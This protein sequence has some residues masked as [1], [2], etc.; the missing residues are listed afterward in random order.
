MI[1]GQVLDRFVTQSPITVMFR[2]TMENAFSADAIDEVFQ[3]TAQQQR[4][5]ELLF[6][7]VVDLWTKRLRR[8]REERFGPVVRG[9]RG[10]PL[11]GSGV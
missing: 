11:N 7:T 9:R 1:F 4:P 3:R 2:A 5:G 10:Q 8:G 6:S